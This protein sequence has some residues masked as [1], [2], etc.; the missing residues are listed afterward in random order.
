ML[1]KNKT[2]MSI[3]LL[4]LMD[5]YFLIEVG[6]MFYY[7]NFKSIDMQHTSLHCCVRK[8]CWL[9]RMKGRV[10]FLFK[11]KAYFLFDF[12]NIFIPLRISAILLN[13]SS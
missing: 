2:D 5:V 7:L 10:F 11:K 1:N 3:S 4:C 8:F 6:L 9:K 13:T 12:S